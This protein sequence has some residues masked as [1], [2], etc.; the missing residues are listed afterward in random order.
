MRILVT[1]GSGFVGSHIVEYHLAKGDKV[2]VLDD[3]STGLIE[4]ISFFKNHPF[5][6]FDHANLLTW[7]DLKKAIA[8]AD[9]IY[10]AAAIVG[11]YRVLADP[12]RVISEN[13]EGC[14]RLLRMIAD[15]GSHSRTI[16]L[17]SS[18]VY[19]ND[20]TEL[21]SEKN[22][23]HIRSHFHPIS[24]YAI[25]KIVNEMLSLSYYHRLK[26]PITLIRLF[27]VTGPRQMGHYGMV[28]PRFIQN[29]CSNE[30]LTIH[31]DGTQTRSFCDVRDAVRALDLLAEKNDSCGEI[32]NVGN[33]CEISINDLAK[34][35]CERSNSRSEIRYLS[36]QEAYGMEFLDIKRRRPDLTKFFQLTKFQYQWSLKQTIDNLISLCR[37][38]L[39]E[40][41]KLNR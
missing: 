5:F 26:L 41:L 9:R 40:R 27:N 34:L 7:P 2:H 3:L 39:C 35:I 11:V 30:P 4:N 10:H 16:L 33:D 20:Q 17:S 38:S 15:S 28:M 14:E 13:I 19:G 8:W 29:A 24:S 1:G 18:S 21:L 23:L 37:E 12:I 32:V 6:K 25:S 31:G 36:Y 22:E